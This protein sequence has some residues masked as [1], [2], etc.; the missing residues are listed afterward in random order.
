MGA[1][2]DTF[3]PNPKN[4]L[5]MCE[6]ICV[7]SFDDGS[8]SALGDLSNRRSK[9]GGRVRIFP[10]GIGSKESSALF[11]SGL[12][13]RS[14]PGAGGIV[15]L[16]SVP[17]ASITKYSKIKVV[18]LDLMARN[19]G[20]Y[21]ENFDILKIDVEGYEIH[22]VQGAKQLLKS[23]RIKNIF[24]EGDVTGAA[25]QKNFRELVSIFSDAGYVP[26]KIGGYSGPS[27]MVQS[28]ID[29]NIEESLTHECAGGEG[30]KRKKCNLWWKLP[31]M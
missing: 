24:L 23:K 28:Q 20:W 9:N 19:L 30:R 29:E 1:V 13:S 8:C 31:S 26:Y 10:V 14:N 7:N 6:S 5:R 15:D 3:E 4:F 21:D 22:V 2:V 17:K 25:K 11:E 18:P 27:R 12:E 16:I